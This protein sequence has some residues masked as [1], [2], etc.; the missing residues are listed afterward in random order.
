[1]LRGGAAPALE[2]RRSCSGRVKQILRRLPV[3][4]RVGLYRRF[5]SGSAKAKISDR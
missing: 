1:M 4:P 2:E 5:G 3:M